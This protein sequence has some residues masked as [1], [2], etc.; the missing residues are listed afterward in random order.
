[1]SMAHF[2]LPG[3]DAEIRHPHVGKLA[4]ILQPPFHPLVAP[5]DLAADVIND[6]HVYSFA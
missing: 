3:R 2:E 6:I 1:M 4:G 5:Q